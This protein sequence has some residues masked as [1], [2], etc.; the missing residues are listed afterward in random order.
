M[1]YVMF[2]KK[3]SELT[4]SHPV[5]FPNHLVHSEV[6]E[7]ILAMGVLGAGPGKDGFGWKAVSA[8]EYDV[9]TGECSGKSETLGL[10][11]RPEED[12]YIIKMNDYGGGMS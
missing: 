5:I 7:A 6:S 12:K 8:G 4:I 9:M 1:K 10:K 11:S 2:E 3:L